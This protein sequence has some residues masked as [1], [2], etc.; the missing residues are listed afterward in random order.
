MEIMSTTK[1]RSGKPDVKR[2]IIKAQHGVIQ[3]LG[4]RLAAA[5]AELKKTQRSSTRKLDIQKRFDRLEKKLTTY[6]ESEKSVEEPLSLREAA[7]IAG[8]SRETI[9]KYCRNGLQHHRIGKGR[10]ARYRIRRGDLET[11]MIESVAATED[12]VSVMRQSAK[13]IKERR[14]WA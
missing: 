4:A 11:Y 6:K 12:L 14:K 9:K 3:R 5:E 2:L 1:Q 10:T 8:C 13:R 7:A